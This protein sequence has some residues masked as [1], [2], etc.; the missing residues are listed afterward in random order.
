MLQNQFI[1]SAAKYIEISIRGRGFNFFQHHFLFLHLFGVALLLYYSY[2]HFNR[3]RCHSVQSNVYRR[4]LLMLRPFDYSF[5]FTYY[6]HGYKS[7]HADILVIIFVSTTSNSCLQSLPKTEADG[8]LLLF[9]CHDHL[10]ICNRH[11]AGHLASTASTF[12]QFTVKIVVQ[13]MKWLK[14]FEK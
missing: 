7:C 13:K 4:Y 8:C 3:L 6:I 14:N 10:H 5:H 1:F 11:P 2:H 12:H 9:S